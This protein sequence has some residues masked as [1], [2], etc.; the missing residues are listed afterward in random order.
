[1]SPAGPAC[2]RVWLRRVR[3]R[4]LRA[5]AVASPRLRR[6]RRSIAG[7]IGTGIPEKRG[8]VRS[9]ERPR[10]PAACCSPRHTREADDW[11][12]PTGEVFNSGFSDSGF[13]GRVEQKAG[14]G[15]SSAAGWQSDFGRDIER[16]RNNSQTVRFYYPTEDSHRFTAGLRSA[17]RWRGFQ[18]VGV[19]G[20]VGSYAQ[21]TD[22]DR[23][24]TATTGRT[25][26]RADVSA[27][28]FHVR[29]FGERLLG[30]ARLE[31]GHRRQRPLR[32]ARVRRSHHLQ[33]GRGR[34]QH[35]A[36]RLD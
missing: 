31:I 29:G 22:Q 36:Q 15:M 20:F 3:R 7:T 27:N 32:P 35:A 9:V 4:D 26:E 19:T 21:V 16:P 30:K 12:S 6:G 17:R 8:S 2:G 33:P 10:P 34:R 5:H 24:A 23:F 18:R 25:I 11:E 13:L 28:D 14:S 1:M